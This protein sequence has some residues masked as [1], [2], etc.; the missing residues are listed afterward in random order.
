MY[1]HCFQKGPSEQ[2]DYRSPVLDAGGKPEYLEKNF[3]KQVWTGNQMDIQHWDKESDLGSSGPQRNDG[4]VTVYKN[5]SLDSHDGAI[6][7]AIV[8]HAHF[9]RYQ[10]H[11]LFGCCL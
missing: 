5:Y 6:Q 2:T 11:P 1:K 8:T 7:T 9:P 10:G 3:G 4:F